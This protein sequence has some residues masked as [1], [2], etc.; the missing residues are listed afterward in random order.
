MWRQYLGQNKTCLHRCVGFFA[1]LNDLCW[2]F[3]GQNSSLCLQVNFLCRWLKHTQE[4]DL[5][6]HGFQTNEMFPNKFYFSYL[7][8]SNAS[9]CMYGYT[10]ISCQVENI[11]HLVI[12]QNHSL[13]KEQLQY[14]ILITCVISCHLLSM[15]VSKVGYV[16]T[17]SIISQLILNYSQI[18]LIMS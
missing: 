8:S 5:R 4:N 17:Y 6:P 10:F 1:D 14:L 18:I 11:A 16:L 12:Y 2:L 9:V 13:L 7:Y 3:E 15:F